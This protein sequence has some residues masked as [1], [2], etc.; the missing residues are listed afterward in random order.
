M[1]KLRPGIRKKRHLSVRLDADAHDKLEGLAIATGQQKSELG[2]LAINCFIEQYI[3]QERL[4]SLKARTHN[5][6][7]VTKN[8]KEPST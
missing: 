3:D 5:L 7:G 1:P 4:E 6:Q 8:G 2:R